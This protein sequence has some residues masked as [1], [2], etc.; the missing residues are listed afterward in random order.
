MTAKSEDFLLQAWKEQID[1]GL[2]LV[3]T[4]IDGAISLQSDWTRANAERCAAYWRALYEAE[5]HAGTELAQRPAKPKPRPSR[6]ARARAA[7]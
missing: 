4:I 1:L 3:E 2:R 7:K 5:G 6:R